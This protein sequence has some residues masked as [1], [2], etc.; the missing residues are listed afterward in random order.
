MYENATNLP[1]SVDWRKEGAVTPVKN[2][3]SC[4][5]CWAFSAV[6]SIEG[7]NAIRSGKLISLS[8]QQL[9]SCDHAKDLGCGGGT[10]IWDFPGL[11]AS[12]YPRRAVVLIS[13]CFAK[14]VSEIISIRLSVGLMDYAF[15][16]IVQNGGLDTEYDYGY[17]SFDLPCQTGKEADRHVVAIDGY[18]DVPQ[19]S[20]EALQ[21]ALAH[22]PVSVAICAS[23]SLQFYSK[24]I[25]DDNGCCV[26]L[27]H[28]VLA[29]GYEPDDENS[30]E[31]P[32]NW[33]IKNSWG[34]GT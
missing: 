21:K 19:G 8:E 17:W 29:V 15:E 30:E 32:G 12:Q 10:T 14:V 26:G 24:G 18:E 1:A 9:V 31:A 11:E 5:S 3:Y 22:Q 33:I 27:N 7:I 13:F 34:S 16:Y 23:S 6:G 4:G 2:Q 20:A 28:G 25:V